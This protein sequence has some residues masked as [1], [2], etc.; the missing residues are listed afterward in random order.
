[1]RFV[2]VGP[3]ALGCLIASKLA[4][5]LAQTGDDLLILDHDRKRSELINS[6]GVL[7]E[8]GEKQ[9]GYPIQCCADPEQIGAADVLFLCVK[10]YDLKAV[11]DY[12][13]PLLVAGTLAIFMQNGISHL[14]FK[15]QVGDA[16]AAYGCTS[17]GATSLG[18]GHTRHAG[19]GKTFLGFLE[20]QDEAV[21]RLLNLSVSRLQM[22]GLVVS[23]TENILDR[24]WAKLFVNVGINALTAIHDCLNGDLLSLPGATSEMKGAVQEAVLVA[25]DKGITVANDPYSATL[26]ICRATAANI[27]SMRQDVLKGKKTEIDTING[28]VVREAAGLGIP[29][30]VNDSLVRRVK[31]IEDGYKGTV[32]D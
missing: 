15:D 28:A 12:C 17:E 25:R 26:E 30:P 8:R 10:S 4:E 22:G 20:K 1:M 19:A 31:E 9:T 6:R 24:L 3:G 18:V 29:V 13:R 14:E 5:A 7:Y 27:S 32:E 16:A 11:L 21:R 23:E 2:L